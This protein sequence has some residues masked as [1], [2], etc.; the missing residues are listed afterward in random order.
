MLI[1]IYCSI[2]E[3]YTF[4][5]NVILPVIP[6]IIR[7]AYLLQYHIIPGTDTVVPIMSFN[8]PSAKAPGRKTDPMMEAVRQGK[9]PTLGEVKRSV[10]VRTSLSKSVTKLTISCVNRPFS[11]GW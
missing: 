3:A 11:G 5:F 6:L 8:E 9:T 7:H 2:V 1:Y 10:K 4:N